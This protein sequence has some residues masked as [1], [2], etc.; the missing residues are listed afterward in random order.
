[1]VEGFGKNL[2]FDV[3]ALVSQHPWVMRGHEQTFLRHPR[4]FIAFL[5][6]MKRGSFQ[7]TS[8]VGLSL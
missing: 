4:S 7:Q 3:T 2:A 6:P 5:S 8:E 1:M